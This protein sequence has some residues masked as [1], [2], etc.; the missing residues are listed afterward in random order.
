M[1][2]VAHPPDATASQ[3]GQRSGFLRALTLTDAIALVAGS[4]I[5]SGVFIVSADIGRTVGSPFWLLVAWALTAVITVL[6]ALAYGELA[7]MYPKAGGQYVF[8]RESLG[9]LTGF[10]YG[11]TL[12]VVIQ[13]GTIAAVAVA[14]GKFLGVLLPSLSP[15]TY[16]W[17][18][19][20][21]FATSGGAIAVGLSDQ[22]VA[23]IALVWVLTAINLRGVR[24]GK[25]V[26]TSLT[27]VKTATLAA[28]IVLGLTVGR[29]AEAITANFTPGIAPAAAAFTP[30]FALVFGTALVGSLFS[31]DAWNNVTFAA[32]EVTN[33]SRNLPLALI[34]G[35]GG[36]TLLYLL[37]NVAYLNMLPF[38]GDP[39]GVSVMA[40][41][42]QYATEDRVGTAAME[43]VF[44]GSG[45]S[46]MAVAILVS[47]FGCN[48]G[49]ILAGSRVLYA[50][51]GDGLFFRAAGTLNA[52]QVPGVGL[53]LQALWTTV[54]CLTGTYS[55][56]LDYVI[57][58]VL[59]F[60]VLTTIG[61]FVLRRTRAE[62]ERPYRALGYPVLPALY[63]LL[64]SLVAIS[65][66]I[67]DKTRTQA[68]SGLVLVL[69]GVPVYFAWR[70]FTPATATRVVSG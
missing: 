61:L 65:L 13:T 66:L 51:A 32:A 15:A 69:V 1:H 58:A 4:M 41:G 29:H 12:F 43:T 46:I 59:I 18:P 64:A 49:L 68:L 67:A 5:G 47:S 20:A 63:I 39:Q 53:I 23:A 19:H 55:Q 56:M 70:R 48:N 17:L 38:H 40:R 57:F 7:A 54:L 50:M 36:V 22:R 60:Y 30:A 9:P 42:I 16:L 37:T 21:S 24:E 2:S 31:A 34:I 10:L 8:L 14:F 26:Q 25:A 52:R 44:G 28:L 6:G 3:L 33:P 45:A 62:I 35:A 11:W 27:I